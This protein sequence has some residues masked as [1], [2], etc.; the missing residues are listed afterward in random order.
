M[1][2]KY[3]LLG[4]LIIILVLTVSVALPT[5]NAARIPGIVILVDMSHG[6]NPGGLEGLMKVVPE[7]YWVVL[8]KSQ[9]DINNLP[10]GAK[11]LAD[12]IRVGGFTDKNL[13]GVDMVI[14]GQPTLLPS[15]SE[16]EAIAKWFKSGSLKALWCAGD[17][18]Y[19]AQGSEKAQEFCNIIFEAIG[20][21]LRCDYVSVED[22][23]EGYYAGKTYRVLGVVD[24]PKELA[25]LKYGCENKVLFHGP[26]AIAAVSS[27]GTWVNPIKNSV[28]GVYV[29][30]H[31][32]DQAVIVEHQPVSPGAPGH[33][34]VAY[35]AGDQGVFPLLAAEVMPNGNI[36]IASGESPY[37]GYQAMVTW[38]YH[39]YVLSGL[40]FVRN[41]ILWATHYMGELSEAKK[42]YLLYDEV[43]KL[44]SMINQIQSSLSKIQSEISSLK[45]SQ[46]SASVSG[47]VA[48]ELSSIKAQLSTL[49]SKLS[50]LESKVSSLSNLGSAVNDLRTKLASLQG[51]VST[52]QS[53]ISTLQSQLIKVAS[54]QGPT[55]G[56]IS[57]IEGAVKEVANAV[58]SLSGISSA[59]LALSIIAIIVALIAIAI[60]VKKSTA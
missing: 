48:K 20:S 2:R 38:E 11:K 59:G 22:H 46:A 23:K 1:G 9:S 53:T 32:S 56:V 13:E 47:E 57:S 58:N 49:S 4:A 43:S 12:E 35:H 3:F 30:V 28:K 14:I 29:I 8:V 19:P 18:D 42:L 26:G 39:G 41:L 34:G 24:P 7:A 55:A 60:V 36:V 27:S 37:S 45:S 15:K 5:V 51:A 52:L 50:D 17:S 21:K 54:S 6:Q 10:A 40:R 25:F 31:T 16:V 44:S 33:L